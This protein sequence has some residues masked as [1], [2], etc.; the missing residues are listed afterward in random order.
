M[1]RSKTSKVLNFPIKG[2]SSV[3]I[4]LTLGPLPSS[5][6]WIFSKQNKNKIDNYI[7]SLKCQILRGSTYILEY[8][9]DVPLTTSDQ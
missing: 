4:P 9:R 2:D 1:T 3:S 5:L 6:D 8:H 7:C